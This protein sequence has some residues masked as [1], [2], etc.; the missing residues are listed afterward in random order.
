MV[1]PE[2]HLSHD[3]KDVLKLGIGIMER[4]PPLSLAF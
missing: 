1:V 3:S 2:H 4:W